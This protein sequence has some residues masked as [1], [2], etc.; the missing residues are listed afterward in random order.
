M[1]IYIIGDKQVHCNNN[2][3]RTAEVRIRLASLV[4][5][6]LHTKQLLNV[7]NL[8]KDDKYVQVKDEEQLLT[9]QRFN[10]VLSKDQCAK[11]GANYK[12]YRSLR[13]LLKII[14]D[15]YTFT[16]KDI[17]DILATRDNVR[18]RNKAPYNGF[19]TLM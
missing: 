8:L 3:L 19:K 9:K 6:K 2:H 15:S 11:Y 16:V 7:F 12:K 4:I 17:R 13:S 18:T 14:S 1:T 5:N 10:W